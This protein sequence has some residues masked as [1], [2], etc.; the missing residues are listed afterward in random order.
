M[1]T[2]TTKTYSGTPELIA[3]CASVISASGQFVPSPC[4]SICKMSESSGLC[5]GCYRTLDEIASWSRLDDPAKRVIW[6]HIEQRLA[7]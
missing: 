1:V 3:A 6:T 7:A 5:L 4:V 2:A